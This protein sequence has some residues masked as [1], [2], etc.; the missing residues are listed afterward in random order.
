[1]SNGGPIQLSES[2]LRA[3]REDLSNAHRHLTAVTRRLLNAMNR[4]DDLSG[5]EMQFNLSLEE[6]K[7]AQ[8]NDKD[9]FIV[10]RSNLSPVG[11]YKDPPGVCYPI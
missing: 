1:M 10:I 4:N 2:E 3:V 11:I 6:N 5:L 9:D 8:D 7:F